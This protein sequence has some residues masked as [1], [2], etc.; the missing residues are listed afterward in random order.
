MRHI[1]V[2]RA[3]Y[4]LATL[5]VVATA[6][7]AYLRSEGFVLAVFLP[8]TRIADADPADGVIDDEWDWRSL[9]ETIFVGQC[10]SCHAA[11]GHLGEVVAAEGGR[12]YLIEFMLYGF[13]GEAEIDGQM[14][15]FYHDPFDDYSNEAIAAVSN[16][17]LV[18]W[19]NA[20]VL[21]ETFEFYVPDEIEAFRD[22]DLSPEDMPE[23][24]P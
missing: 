21:P 10:R 12:D 13:D 8:E 4:I 5:L 20:D 6:A 18:S 9:G 1:Y 23:R 3:V 11:L 19:G 22:R 15:D 16:H 14:I 2:N 17:M 24:R 7:F